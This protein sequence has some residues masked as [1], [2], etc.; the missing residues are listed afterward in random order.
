MIYTGRQPGKLFTNIYHV[1]D[2]SDISQQTM[3]ASSGLLELELP[4]F[5]F[6]PSFRNVEMW[7]SIVMVQKEQRCFP[8]KGQARN[9]FWK[10]MCLG[11][12]GRQWNLIDVL[13]HRLCSRGL[14]HCWQATKALLTRHSIA[15]WWLLVSSVVCNIVFHLEFK[16]L[17]FIAPHHTCWIEIKLLRIAEY[18]FLTKWNV[19]NTQTSPSIPEGCSSQQT[20]V[21]ERA[22]SKFLSV[23]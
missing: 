14:R 4:C 11:I 19:S 12:A 2:L 10:H 6:N 13:I 17:K 23:V 20:V 3:L 15:Y 18:F 16:S 22:K 5:L 8:Y 21:Q 7:N 9:Y 1:L